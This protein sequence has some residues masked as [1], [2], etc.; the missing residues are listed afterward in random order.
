MQLF[1]FV[2]E[3]TVRKYKEDL[4]GEIEPQ[5]LELVELAKKGLKTLE[6]KKQSLQAQVLHS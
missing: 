5:I 3:S 6:R 2:N 1:L 4:T